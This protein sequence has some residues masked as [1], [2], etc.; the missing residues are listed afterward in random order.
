MGSVGMASGSQGSQSKKKQRD[1]FQPTHS[2]QSFRAPFSTGF[3]GHS[4]R[5]PVTCHQCGK[6]GHIRAH[7]PQTP[8]QLRP[9]PPPRSQTPGACFGCGGFGHVARFCPQ[10][11]G[12]HSESGLVQQPRSGQSFGQHQQRGTQSQP[13]YCQTTTVQGPQGD[14]GASSSALNSTT[15]GR[16]FAVTTAAP[17]PPPVIATQTLEASIVRGTFL[18]F[19]SLAGVLFD[20]GASHSFIAASFVLALGLETEELNPPLFV[21]TP[22]GGRTPL[23]R[24]CRG[25]ELVILDHHFVFDFIVLGMSGFDLIL[26]M[27]WLSTFRATIDCFK[28]RVRIC[29]LEG[30]CLEFFGERQESFEPYLYEPR[31]KGSIAYLLA[32]LT[33]DEDL[34]TRGEL[35]RVVSRVVDAQQDNEETGVLHTKFLSGEA[36]EG[37][38]IHSDQSIRFQGKIMPPRRKPRRGRA[39]NLAR[40]P[41]GRG[42]DTRLQDEGSQHDGNPGGRGARFEQERNNSGGNGTP[43]Q[44]V[45]DFVTA[46]TAANILNQ[47]RVDAESRAREITKDFCRMNPPS[48]DGSIINDDN[49]RVHLVAC[50]LSG[51]ANE[52][53]ESVLAA[54]RDA[55]RVARA[56]KNVEAPDIENLTWAEF[57]KMFENQYFPESYREQLRDKFEKFKQG[58]HGAMRGGNLW[59]VWAW[60]LAVREV[61]VRRDRGIPSNLL[62]VSRVSGHLFSTGFGGHS[63]RPPVTCHQCGQEGHIRAHC[64]QTPSQHRA[65]PPP[66]SKTPGACFGCGGFGLVARFCPQKVGARSESG[67]VQQP[68]SGQSFGQHQQ[69]G[70]QSQP[71]YCQTTT[72]QGPQGDRGASSS[73]LNPTTQGRVFAVTTAAPPPPPVITT[74]ALEA[75]IMRG[76]FLLFNSFAGVLFDSGA[77]HSFIAA[78]F[79]L[80]LGLETEELNPPLFV[81]TPIGGRTPLDRICRGCELVILDHHFVFDF[82]VLGMSGFDLILGMD[83]LSM[84]RATIDYFKRRV[85]ICTL[86]GGCLEFSGNVKSHLNHTCMSRGIKG[87][88]LTCWLA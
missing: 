30:G 78:S 86:E 37:R 48:F 54:R 35:P 83:W 33:L 19:N 12:A 31:D 29:T 21:D 26:G 28:R 65:P 43:N 67:S 50:Q 76:T 52:W 49:M 11:V 57:E 68:R 15:Q 56:A 72:V 58:M 87:R 14:R 63:S 38:S 8:S 32:S 5:P 17:P 7:C 73:A 36:S 77:S 44:F 51:E 84:F 3:G 64:P 42:R 59:E 39:T 23:D 9:P 81:D 55:R 66:H 27:D 53:W 75:S 40:G 46:L 88:L 16:V 79:V 10:K 4:F 34:S 62:I 18:L 82:I 85:R 22:I 24:I 20:S 69:R 45:V 80:A 6:E 74:Q 60:H 61:K 13:H 41:R 71:H 1:T 47:P 70:T 2:Q 25:C